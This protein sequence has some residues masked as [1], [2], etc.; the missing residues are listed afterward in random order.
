MKRCAHCKEEKNET[1]FYKN[2]HNKDGLHTECCS[3]ST[4]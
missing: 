1:D 4:L 2:K 3:M